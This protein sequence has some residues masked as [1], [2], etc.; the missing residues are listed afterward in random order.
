MDYFYS[1]NMQH[2]MEINT[3]QHRKLLHDFYRTGTSLSL[4]FCVSILYILM[5]LRHSQIDEKY[6]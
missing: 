5:L 4:H 2:E 3:K 1:H 6:K